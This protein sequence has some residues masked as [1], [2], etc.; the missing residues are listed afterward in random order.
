MTSNLSELQ[1]KISY[2][3][4]RDNLVNDFYVPC[5]NRSMFYQRA[6][7]Y[8]TSSSLALAAS[9]IANLIQAGGKIQLI[10][11]PEFTREDI[12]RHGLIAKILKAYEG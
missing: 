4:G 7:G 5:L 1:L 3:T 2:R 6:V 11:S 8:F 9:G 12:V 10:A